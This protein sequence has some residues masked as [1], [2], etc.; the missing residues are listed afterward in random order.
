[1]TTR[2]RQTARPGSRSLPV[3]LLLTLLTAPLL[4][5]GAQAQDA[6]QIVNQT[7][8][9]YSD[10]RGGVPIQGLTQRSM[11]V[12]PRGVV[13]GCDGTPLPTYQGFT[14]GL[15][16]PDPADPTGTEVKGPVT[17]TPTA[18]PAAPGL[19]AGIGPN[20]GNANPF[21]LSDTD[22]GRFSLLLD[23][24]RGQLDAGRTYILLLNPP[25]GSGYKQRRIRITIGARDGQTLSYTAASL[26]GGSV[27]SLNGNMTG[28]Q[29]TMATTTSDGGLVLAPLNLNLTDCE[30]RGVQIGKTCDRS[31]AEPG[32]TVV[33]RIVVQPSSLPMGDIQIFDTLPRGFDLRTDSVLGGVAGKPVSITVSHS[34]SATVFSPG[35]LTLQAGQS[36]TVAYAVQITPDALSGDGKNSAAVT[37]DSFLVRNGTTMIS[38]VTDGPAVFTLQVRQGLL[39][40]TG[41][42][43]GRVWV[44]R[45]RDGEQQSGE[46]GLPYAVVLLD[47]STRIVADVNG[48]FSVANV[49]AGYHAAALD[50]TSVPGYVLARNHRFI[51]RNSQSRLV[52]VSPGGTIRLNF[53]V[54]PAQP[55]TQAAGG[56]K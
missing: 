20:V 40:D 50:M 27:S 4:P 16:D 13:L 37:A 12:D 30:A 43:L 54:V 15:Y 47:D 45:S 55:V 6:G 19:P 36:L 32:D 3:A 29:T 2:A 56:A 35:T 7:S 53:G 24:S 14:I 25:P 26:D 11:L 22:K 34:G 51:E 44:D 1:M 18:V 23:P 33:Y 21:P 28:T 48:L 5:L 9:T 10:D 39:T 41:T 38:P 49:T 31:A 17:L 46:P 8:Y 42:I 52:R